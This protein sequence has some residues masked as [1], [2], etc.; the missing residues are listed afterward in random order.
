MT[1]HL[2]YP[3]YIILFLYSYAT[4]QRQGVLEYNV[5]M[6]GKRVNEWDLILINSHLISLIIL[7]GDEDN[8]PF[9]FEAVIEDAGCEFHLP[10]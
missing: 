8:W 10:L 5:A 7:C 2:N 9:G 4:L 6:W 1:Y 3:G